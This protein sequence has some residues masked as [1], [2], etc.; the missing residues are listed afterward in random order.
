MKFASLSLKRPITILMI[1]LGLFVLGLVSLNRIPLGFLPSTS[2]EHAWI[3]FPYR[4]STPKDVEEKILIPAEDALATLPKLKDMWARASAESAG[5]SLDFEEGVDMNMMVAEIR[6]RLDRIR[7]DFPDDFER[8]YIWR[9]DTGDI[10]ILWLGYNLKNNLETNVNIKDEIETKVR[11][12]NGVSQIDIEG[13]IT[14]DILIKVDED[15]LRQFKISQYTLLES[16]RNNNINY[17][18]GKIETDETTYYVRTLNKF[19]S[20][21]EIRNM[22]LKGDIYVKDVAKITREKQQEDDFRRINGHR[23]LTFS[24]HKESSSNTVRTSEEVLKTLNKIENKY[25]IEIYTLFNQG[26]QIKQSLQNLIQNGIWGA[27]LAI[28]VLY[29]FLKKLNLTFIIAFEIPL[30][31]IFTLGVMYFLNI[32]LN[33]ISMMGLMI[34]IGMLVDNAVVVTESIYKLRQE[35]KGLIKSIIRGTNEI[36]LA[37]FTASLTTMIVFLPLFLSSGRFG[38]FLK[39]IA[40]TIIIALSMSLISSLLLIPLFSFVFMKDAGGKKDFTLRIKGFYKKLLSWFINHRIYTVLI[41][42]IFI[43]LS[44][45]PIKNIKKESMNSNS[46]NDIVIRFRNRGDITQKRLKEIVFPV[47]KK[48]IENKKE[49]HTQYVTTRIRSRGI[50]V[51]LF[52]DPDKMDVD[53]NKIIDTIQKKYLP[54]NIP[55]V[56]I[57]FGWGHHSGGG[58]SER[59][60]VFNVVLYGKDFEYLYNIASDLAPVFEQ[61]EGVKTVDYEEDGET[62]EVNVRLNRNKTNHLGIN[63]WQVLS[64][65][66]SMLRSREIGEL[67]IGGT[68]MEL[69]VERNDLDNLRISDIENSNIYLQNG[70][71]I[72]LKDISN[73]N[74][75]PGMKTIVHDNREVSLNMTLTTDI[76]DPTVLKNNIMNLTRGYNFPKG[77]GIRMGEKFERERESMNEF[78]FF[79]I[80]ALLLVYMVMA[81][82]F[83]SINMPLGIIFGLPISIL[84]SL[85]GIYLTGGRINFMSYMGFII[86]VGIAVNNGI[87]IIDHINRLRIKGYS[88]VEAILQGGKD[89]FRPVLMTTFTTIIG[90][91]PMSLGFSDTFF[92]KYSTLTRTVIFGLFTSMFVTLLII[93][94]L[95]SIIDDISEF[96]IS[97]IRKIFSKED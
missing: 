24:V 72:K 46:G 65:I 44:F 51:R 8:Y 23:S 50:R 6:D 17:S 75:E 74:I 86:L 96:H 7:D 52:L 40:A 78:F 31:I 30:S 47:E 41:I 53:N 27:L 70:E 42:I 1:F 59:K 48:L 67:N 58:A 3:S 81:S 93:P 22:P 97:K 45:I 69:A 92:I 12:I 20:F 38:D 26:A 87:V 55:G 66:S 43:F 82:L 80:M 90:V 60:G 4:A 64:S 54:K 9:H 71:V 32:N 61:I 94:V 16:L 79:M 76:E 39:Y 56:D 34:A 25:N 85:W 2:G 13:V 10:P 11:A 36:G 35:G 28:V 84:G 68:Q 88:K 63:S 5:I 95:Y 73:F 19:N 57:R 77:Y 14:N 33:I 83:E 89:R 37:V 49:L 21:D 15:K 29:F 91:F 18:M 62:Q